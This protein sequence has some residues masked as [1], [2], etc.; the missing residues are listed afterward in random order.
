M[1][2]FFIQCTFFCR[3]SDVGGG[4]VLETVAIATDGIREVDR[5]TLQLQLLKQELHTKVN[6]IT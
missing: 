2:K 4:V 5:L 1:S 6:M 3:D